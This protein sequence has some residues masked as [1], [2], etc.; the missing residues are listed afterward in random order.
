MSKRIAPLVA[1]AAVLAFVRGAHGMES[2]GAGENVTVTP[3]FAD[4]RFPYVTYGSAWAGTPAHR[5]DVTVP[6]VVIV[7][8][9]TAS[10]V[11]V[12]AAGKMAFYLGN[13]VDGIGFGPAEVREGAMPPLL[14]GDAEAASGGFSNLIVVG[15]DN[16]LAKRF[17]IVFKGPSVIGR[18]RDGKQFLF[19]GGDSEAA[20][21]AALAYMADVRLNAK[22]GAYKTFFNFVRLRGYIETENWRAAA[23]L[24]RSPAGLSACGRNMALAAPR[25]AKAPDKVRAH[26][27][28]RNGLLYKEIPEAVSAGDKTL[29]SERWRAAMIAC[30]GCHQGMGEIP[31]SRKFTPVASI[32]AKHQRIAEGFGFE[33][34]CETCHYG[35]TAQAGY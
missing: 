3:E 18:E 5:P 19:V 11:V 15:A 20:T 27:R 8:G 17:D 22:S 7:Y 1:L 10:P 32:H 31:R 13:W 33:K 21:L 16:R 34:G 35:K 30:Y 28:H 26:I 24:V 12:A 14:V 4:Q 23:D 29:A 9:E 25:M 6:N 2:A